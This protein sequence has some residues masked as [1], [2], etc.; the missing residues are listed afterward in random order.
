MYNNTKTRRNIF[1]DK[2]TIINIYSIMTEQPQASAEN[3]TTSQDQTQQHNEDLP[4]ATPRDVRLLH[5]ILA[6][7][8]VTAY[9][10]R[11]PLQLMDF[12]YRYTHGVLQDAL[13]YS[14][15]AGAS[16]STLPAGVGS[17]SSTSLT[18]DDIRLAVGARVNYQFKPAP[19]KELLLE[20]AQE[21][22]KRPLPPVPQQYGIRLP[23]EKYCLTS[24]EWQL[25]DEKDET[26]TEFIA[27]RP[28]IGGKSTPDNNN[29]TNDSED[30]DEQMINSVKDEEDNNENEEDGDAIMG[31][32]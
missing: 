23:P 21:K 10:D 30:M 20:M 6:S 2:K 28:T 22:N 11:V 19:P 8:G 29:N 24:K 26:I 9:Q 1:Q 5:L 3:S 13:Y 18:V 14:D 4:D 7:M 32:V 17:S 12:A 27:T 16:T 25:D 15:H 31:E